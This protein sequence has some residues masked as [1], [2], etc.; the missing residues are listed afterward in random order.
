MIFINQCGSINTMSENKLKD[1]E[2]G[3]QIP[4]TDEIRAHYSRLGKLGGAKNK[5]KG[6]E[7]FSR[8]SKMKKGKK[9]RPRKEK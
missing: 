3:T 9:Y 8:I 7:Y 4:I 1:L 5:A 2:I 6:F